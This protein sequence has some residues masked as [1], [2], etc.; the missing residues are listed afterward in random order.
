MNMKCGIKDLKINYSENL[1]LIKKNC[2]K[3]KMQESEWSSNFIFVSAPDSLQF[4]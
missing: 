3:L 4:K 1:N 2:I